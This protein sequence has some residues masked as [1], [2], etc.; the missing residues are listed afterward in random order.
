MGYQPWGR[1][2]SDTTELTERQRVRAGQHCNCTS[3]VEVH[4]EGQGLLV[5]SV[6]ELGVGRGNGHLDLERFY[7]KEMT[8][9]PLSKISWAQGY[10][11]KTSLQETPWVRTTGWIGKVM[12]LDTSGMEAEPDKGKRSHQGNPKSP[13]SFLIPVT[14][15]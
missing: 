15:L 13:G 7:Q 3:Q 2:E 5:R 12:V 4:G 6:S 10:T 14:Q 8:W 11:N 1:K 9:S